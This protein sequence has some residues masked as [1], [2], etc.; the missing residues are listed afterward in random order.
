MS[1]PFATPK[2]GYSELNYL[3][4]KIPNYLKRDIMG[5]SLFH[6]SLFAHKHGEKMT[7]G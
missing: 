3:E 2:L 7:D 5:M 6:R 4:S 1:H